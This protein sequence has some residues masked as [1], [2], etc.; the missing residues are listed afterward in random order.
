MKI[1]PC[2]AHPCTAPHTTVITSEGETVLVFGKGAD[3]TW[4]GGV[5][6]G[7]PGAPGICV[8]IDGARWH[9][10]GSCPHCS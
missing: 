1:T 2:Q 5:D 6:L 9:P 3:V 8:D 10:P 4:K 7:P